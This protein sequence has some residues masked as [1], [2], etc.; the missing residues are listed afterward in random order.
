[1]LGELPDEIDEDRPIG[2]EGVLHGTTG[3]RFIYEACEVESANVLTYRLLIALEF[4]DNVLLNDLRI[5]RDHQ[6]NLNAPV[7]GNTFEMPLELPRTLRFHP[8]IIAYPHILKY[9][10]M[11]C[12]GYRVMVPALLL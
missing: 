2:R 5:F 1:M 3:I 12:W 7:I 4:F 10:S 9:M 6:K 8:E 11:S